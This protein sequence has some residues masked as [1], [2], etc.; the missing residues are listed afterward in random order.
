[1]GV[2]K[3]LFTLPFIPSHQGRGNLIADTL[4]LATG[5]FIILYKLFHYLSTKPFGFLE[6]TYLHLEDY[7]VE[8]Y[9]DFG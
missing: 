2:A 5:Q 7:G 4:K 6:V 9:G 3:S 8:Y 1:M